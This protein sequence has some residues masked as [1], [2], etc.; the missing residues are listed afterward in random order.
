MKSKFF[1][2]MDDRVVTPAYS[3]SLSPDDNALRAFLI[4]SD[5]EKLRQIVREEIA[6]ALRAEKP[7]A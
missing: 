5:W 4:D 7:A 2:D 1:G 6:A 3:I